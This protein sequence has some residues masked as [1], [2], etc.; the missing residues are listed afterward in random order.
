MIVKVTQKQ[1]SKDIITA[2]NALNSAGA[3]SCLDSGNYLIQGDQA[4]VGKQVSGGAYPYVVFLDGQKDYMFFINE[5]VYLEGVI[6]AVVNPNPAKH[7]FFILA[8]GKKL[9]LN[10]VN[11]GNTGRV[12]CGFMSVTR[13]G[14]G[15]P[16][17][18][19]S[20][21]GTLTTFKC[22]QAYDGVKK[23]TIHIYCIDQNEIE[24]TRGT[25]V[26]AY[27]GM[28][29]S[30]YNSSTSKLT[31][32]NG[33]NDYHPNFCFY[34]RIMAT[35]IINQSGDF[36]VPYCPAPNKANTAA[37]AEQTSAYS[38]YGLQYYI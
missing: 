3:S 12:A 30:N 9:T 20:K 34:G 28:F 14:S 4:Y 17:Q 16:T 22:D 25:V 24:M 33:S 21:I 38:V 2:Q 6:F 7:Q 11:S 26:E 10:S 27:L 15:N 13:E 18:Y 37:Y 5:S 1:H 19:Y 23:P 35:S 8:P 31:V 36:D 29:Q 32:T